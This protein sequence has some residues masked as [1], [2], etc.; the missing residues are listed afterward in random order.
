L[1]LAYA[2]TINK[3]QG[4]T[5]FHAGLHLKYDIFSHGQLYFAFSRTKALT[6]IKVQLPH[7]MHGLIGLTCNVVYE[8]TFLWGYM[9]LLNGSAKSY[10]HDANC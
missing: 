2:M 3:S 7:T 5:L 4:Q 1:W 9:H 8:E 10:I 6:N